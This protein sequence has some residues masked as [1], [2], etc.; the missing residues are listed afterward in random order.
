[1][2]DSWASHRTLLEGAINRALSD[3]RFGHGELA[4]EQVSASDP[5]E[6]E[7]AALVCLRATE[8]IAGSPDAALA[9]AT[10]LALVSQMGLV[11]T[12]L[13]SQNGA[14]SLSTAWGMP[15]ALNAGDALFASAQRVLLSAGLEV[16][17]DQRLVAVRLLD[18]A[19]RSFLDA[20]HAAGKAPD[21]LAISQ[22]ALLPS[23]VRLAALFGGASDGIKGRLEELAAGWSALPEEEMAA[24]L[25]R[26]LGGLAVGS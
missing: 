22:R 8:A 17:A 6:Y 1:M 10:A 24:A 21:L 4:R 5:A 26:D 20:I 3:L 2:Q 7:T 14:A 12:S 9:A 23:A 16:T 11:F 13:E 18:E 19:A 25:S 15:R